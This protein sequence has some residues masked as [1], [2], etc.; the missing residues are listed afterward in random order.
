MEIFGIIMTVL[1]IV[2]ALGII[3]VYVTPFIVVEV[4]TLKYRIQK[5]LADK[6][7]DIDKRSDERRN[8]D[9]R[10]REKDFELANKKLD[11]K[12]SKLDKQI[13]LYD[14]KQTLAK[15]LKKAAANQKAELNSKNTKTNKPAIVDELAVPTEADSLDAE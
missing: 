11:A 12:L 10:K 13:K 7:A 4:R 9:E 8:R 15:E 6:K 5:G 1:L 3:G 14:E 2:F